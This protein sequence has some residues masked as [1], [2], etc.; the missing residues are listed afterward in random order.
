MDMN[1][2]WISELEDVNRYLGKWKGKKLWENFKRYNLY[3]FGIQREEREK[4]A[5]EIVEIL[6]AKNF[7]KLMIDTTPQIQETQ[8]T[9][10]INNKKLH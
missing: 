3:V 10:S 4:K 9:R 7:P 5:E 2:K 8:W 6:K 1:E